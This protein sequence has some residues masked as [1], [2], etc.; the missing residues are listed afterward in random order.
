MKHANSCQ[1][2]QYN[3]IMKHF[4]EQRSENQTI[5]NAHVSSKQGSYSSVV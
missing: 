1:R 5:K 2:T 3:T 4:C